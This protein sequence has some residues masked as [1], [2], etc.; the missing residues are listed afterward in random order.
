MRR[1]AFLFV[2]QPGELEIQALLLAVSLRRFL[3]CAHELVACVPTPSELWGTPS[4]AT[5]SVLHRLG[6][7]R[8]DIV[9]PLGRAFPSANKIGCLAAPVEADKR[10]FLDSDIQLLRPFHDEVRFDVPLNLRR[11]DPGQ[12]SAG[13]AAPYFQSSVI[14]AAAHVDLAGVWLA[15]ARA[16]PAD[17]QRD[18]WSEQRSL[19]AAVHRLG[20]AYDRLDERYD[21][22]THEH[23]LDPG[24]LPYF[25][26]YHRPQVVA[27]ETLL[28]ARFREALVE[29]PE[30]A[31]LA[32]GHDGWASLVR[33]A[34]P[35]G[36]PVA[37]TSSTALIVL[38]MHRSGTSAVAGTCRRLGVDLG[39][40]FLPYG[41]DNPHGHW[42]PLEVVTAHDLLL[43]ALGSEWDD[44]RA[45][46]VGWRES[47]AAREARERI[48]AFI[49]GA[50]ARAPFWGVKDPRLCRVLPLWLD[51][52]AE[53]NCEPRILMIVR[54]PAEV[55]ASLEARSG[56]SSGHAHLLWLR[57]LVE[58]EWWSRSYPRVLVSY[59]EYLRDWRGT[60]TR[61]SAVLDLRLDTVAAPEPD[62]PPAE[63]QHHRL[64][65]CSGSSDPARP[66]WEEA[67]AAYQALLPYVGT[68]VVAAGPLFEAWGH[69]LA[70]FDQY[71]TQ[72]R[73]HDAG[74]TA[75]RA[76]IAE[77]DERI[78]TLRT[79]LDVGHERLA[80]LETHLGAMYASR[81]WRITSPLRAL[82]D[83]F[84]RR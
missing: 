26:H 56:M 66:I 10:F 28:A 58:M 41:D 84:R 13:E 62:Q 40:R 4:E 35:H 68:D 19:A 64:D 33:G 25:C 76:A 21:H 9:N 24:A 29:H 74:A 38:G 44:V 45:L 42:E 83:A 53:R 70:A 16:L 73:T 34:R 14:A 51:V 7:R 3:H 2:C 39:T 15:C 81:S 18:Q 59:D 54:D 72:A 82:R 50:F 69:R 17:P 78:A 60:M 20:V 31:D 65:C 8:V 63:L 79:A 37:R 11:A 43:R 1:F 57:Y 27:R 22:P 32:A 77:R 55:A 5:R 75:L 52:L 48:R 71:H 12:G 67:R 61:A 46:P 6:V 30:I 23:P 49:A 47:E 36:R 80:A